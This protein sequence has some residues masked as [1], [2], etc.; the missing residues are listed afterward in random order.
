[1]CAPRRGVQSHLS[2]KHLTLTAQ[3]AIPDTSVR[4]TCHAVQGAATGT[5]LSG[6]HGPRR[7]ALV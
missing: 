1:M 5:Q 7:M 2:H 4:T 3:A 6:M